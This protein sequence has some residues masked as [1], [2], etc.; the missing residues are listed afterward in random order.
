MQNNKLYLEKC[1]IV[2]ILSKEFSLKFHDLDFKTHQIL[3]AI[4]QKKIQ[5][6]MPLEPFMP[7]GPSQQTCKY[8]VQESDF[9]M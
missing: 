4:F 6:S 8:F 2:C 9:P 3:H 1:I 7:F 5:A